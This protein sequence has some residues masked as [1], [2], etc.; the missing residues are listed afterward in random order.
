MKTRRK[1]KVRRAGFLTKQS[2]DSNTL[3]RQRRCVTTAHPVRRNVAIFKLVRAFD[4][5]LLP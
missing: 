2:I 3:E 4:H 1:V 5:I